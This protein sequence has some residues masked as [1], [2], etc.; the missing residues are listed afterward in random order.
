MI[1]YLFSTGIVN[2]W[3]SLP[4]SVICAENAK[5]TF[6]NRCGRFWAKQE[7]VYDYTKVQ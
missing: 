5:N 2:I 4:A 6:K 3:N 1:E 7:L